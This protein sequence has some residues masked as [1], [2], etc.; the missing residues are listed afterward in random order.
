MDVVKEIEAT[1]SKIERYALVEGDLIL[2]E[3]GD[4]DKLGRGTVWRGELPLCLHQASKPARS[5]F[6]RAAKQTTGIASI[7]MTQLKALPVA[8]PPRD[9]QSLYLTRLDQ[10]TAQRTAE[11]RTSATSEEFFT[12]LQSCAFRGVL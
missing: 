5:Y 4:P 1:A 8:V 11:Q 10:V 3:G 9:L 12:S 2:T 6:M 7:N